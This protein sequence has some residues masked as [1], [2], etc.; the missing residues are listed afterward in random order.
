LY[1]KYIIFINYFINLNKNISYSSSIRIDLNNYLNNY[2]K[3]IIFYLLEEKSKDNVVIFNFDKNNINIG[4]TKELNYSD[5]KLKKDFLYNNN[6]VKQTDLFNQVKEISKVILDLINLL[7]LLVE[8]HSSIKKLKKKK[9]LLLLNDIFEDTQL[10]LQNFE[11]FFKKKDYERNLLN[12]KEILSFYSK[13]EDIHNL[14]FVKMVNYLKDIKNKI[15]FL[16]KKNAI[17]YKVIK[18]I[19]SKGGIIGIKEVIFFEKKGKINSYIFYSIFKKKKLALNFSII[20]LFC[21]NS[22]YVILD[23]IHIKYF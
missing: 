15:S 1:Y 6:F 7:Y 14:D 17:Y 19:S 11:E 20:D 18:T 12:L 23:N 13:N 8:N 9:I 3:K 5:F 16:I 10:L 22:P 4:Q 2:L 21:R